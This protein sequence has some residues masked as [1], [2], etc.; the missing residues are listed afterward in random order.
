[1]KNLLLLGGHEVY[2][3]M[4]VSRLSKNRQFPIFDKLKSL[5]RIRLQRAKPSCHAFGGVTPQIMEIGW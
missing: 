4:Q 1:V 2:G 3:L 5:W